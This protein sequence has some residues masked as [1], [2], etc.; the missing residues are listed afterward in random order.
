MKLEFSWEAIDSQTLRAK[1]PGG[2]L[3]RFQGHTGAT[4]LTFVP[5][6]K[7][8]WEVVVPGEV[9]EKSRVHLEKLEHDLNDP[10]IETGIKS[11]MKAE[12]ENLRRFI[13]QHT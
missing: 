13:D 7:H 1:V 11:E 6:P 10:Y 4:A 2:W 9:M 5:D 3:L 12:A 8:G